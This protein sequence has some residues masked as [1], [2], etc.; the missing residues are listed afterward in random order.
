MQRVLPA[1]L[2]PIFT[3]SDAR[4]HGVSARHLRAWTAEGL[5]ERLDRG[6]YLRVGRTTNLLDLELSEL[7]RR[8]PVATVCLLSALARHGLS[9]AIPSRIDVAVPRG[10][11]TPALHLPIAWHSF[12]RD[13]FGVGRQELKVA[14]GL[15]VG[16]YDPMRCLVDLFR[17]RHLYGADLANEAL[18]RWLSTPSARP[19]QLLTMARLFPK[20]ESALRVSLRVLL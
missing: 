20:A 4:R 3:Y 6:L 15:T 17:L 2:G 13:T 18:R 19:G 1:S 11:R 12:A 7:A 14:P 5:I 8:T 10:H 16:L 9:D